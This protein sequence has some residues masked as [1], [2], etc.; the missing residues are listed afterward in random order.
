[1]QFNKDPTKSFGYNSYLLTWQRG[2]RQMLSAHSARENWQE[3]MMQI[4]ASVI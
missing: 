1:M 3:I 4:N 2:Y